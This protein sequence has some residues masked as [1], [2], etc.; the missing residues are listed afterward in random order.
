MTILPPPV[1]HSG[2]ATRPLDR[3]RGKWGMWLFIATEA[4]LFALLFFSYFYL[5]AHRPEWPAEEDPKYKLA[6]LML[7]V[8]LTSSAVLYWGERAVKKGALGQLQICLGG[9][10]LLGIGF[11][12]ISSV[13][14][15]N[16]LKVL[17]PRSNA[18]GSIFYAITSLHAAHLILGLM[19]LIFVLA[20]ALAGHFDAHRHLAVKN[21]AL[22]WHFVD[23]I[24]VCVVAIL[25]LSPRLYV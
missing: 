22:Y 3:L 20:R 24:W 7:A 17:T 19:M 4:M 18:Y 6:L 1:G 21:A 8:L 9:T 15:A 10:I 14:Y 25:Y 5:G 11:L 13:E 12:V 16:H 23:V 2:S